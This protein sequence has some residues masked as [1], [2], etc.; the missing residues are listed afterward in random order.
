VGG[1]PEIFEKARI[2]VDEQKRDAEPPG[3]AVI[4]F[5]P[6]IDRGD[7]GDSEHQRPVKQL[8]LF[9]FQPLID[10]AIIPEDYKATTT[11]AKAGFPLSLL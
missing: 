6:M 5:H 11:A 7:G 3:H 10:V 8:Y 2:E 1:V 9:D 4:L